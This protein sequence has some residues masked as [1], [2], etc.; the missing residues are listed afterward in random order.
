MFHVVSAIHGPNSGSL[1]DHA[2]FVMNC[3]YGPWFKENG[4]RWCDYRIKTNTHTFEYDKHA[5][6]YIFWFKNEADALAFKLR[7]V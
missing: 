4:I 5:F 1:S 2:D 3:Q 7:W 6:Y